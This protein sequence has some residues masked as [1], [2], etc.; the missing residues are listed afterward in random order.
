MRAATEGRPYA[1]P[2]CPDTPTN[3]RYTN[4]HVGEPPPVL[5][6]LVFWSNREDLLGNWLLN[7]GLVAPEA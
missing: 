6:I 5:L 2:V 4:H 7:F 3:P 1:N